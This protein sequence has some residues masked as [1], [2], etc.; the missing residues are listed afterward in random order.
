ML[1]IGFGTGQKNVIRSRFYHILCKSEAVLTLLAVMHI[2]EMY[3]TFAQPMGCHGSEMNMMV[4]LQSK[5]SG[6]GQIGTTGG[7]LSGL[8]ALQAPLYA[9]PLLAHMHG[10]TAMV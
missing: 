3:V 8:Q 1:W 7:S 6:F 9:M 4:P 5:E 10:N 2:T